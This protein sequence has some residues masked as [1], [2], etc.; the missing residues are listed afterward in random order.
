MTLPARLSVPDL[1]GL[2]IEA[3]HLLQV[4]EYTTGDYTG[5]RVKSRSPALYRVVC[6]LLARELHLVEVADITG[7]SRNT[8]RAIAR[9]EEGSI[10]QRKKR[11]ARSLLDLA[12]IGAA[13]ALQRISSG[14][15]IISIK[16]LMI[17]VGIATDKG[18]L[19]AGEATARVEHTQDVPDRDELLR[20]LSEQAKP[21]DVIDTGT[22]A[23]AAGTKEPGAELGPDQAAGVPGEG[24]P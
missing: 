16:D 2:S 19:N 21:A 8:I 11:L 10:D 4:H 17:A 9:A 13:S 6:E 12:E 23:R 1:P 14:K 18:L 22:A 5:E 20:L 7:L 3:V 15:E 24:A